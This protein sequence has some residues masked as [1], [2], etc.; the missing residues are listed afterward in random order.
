MKHRSEKGQGKEKSSFEYFGKSPVA[1]DVAHCSG[2]GTHAPH[3]FGLLAMDDPFVAQVLSVVMAYVAMSSDEQLKAIIDDFVEMNRA[4][5]AKHPITDMPFDQQEKV[6]RK[7]FGD[8][9]AL[10][11]VAGSVGTELT[12]LMAEWA[13]KATSLP[14]VGDTPSDMVN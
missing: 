1:H 14:V 4:A 12:E 13:M 5:N 2:H 8:I 7:V 3:Y 10:R 9:E 6:V 11:F